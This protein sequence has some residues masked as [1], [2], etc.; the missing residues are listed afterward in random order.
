MYYTTSL[1]PDSLTAMCASPR[2]LCWLCSSRSSY[3]PWSVGTRTCRQQT[4]GVVTRHS[5]CGFIWLSQ[6]PY[7]MAWQ[8]LCYHSATSEQWTHW[9]GRSLVHCREVVFFRGCTLRTSQLGWN[10][11][12]ILRR[13]STSQRACYQFSTLYLY[14]ACIYLCSTHSWS[15]VSEATPS[16]SSSRLL[17]RVSSVGR[18]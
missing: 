10:S 14:Y 6:T 5:G 7:H 13:L 3:T 1:S 8:W 2:S 4:G 11:L 18:K 17:F 9:G 16:L 15:S 12:S